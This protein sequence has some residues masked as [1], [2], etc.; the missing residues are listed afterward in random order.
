MQLQRVRLVR[1]GAGDATVNLQSSGGTHVRPTA[2]IG[3]IR[4]GKVEK[5][6]KENR[7]MNLFLDV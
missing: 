5:K 1:I 6:G 2:E 7:R 3:R 4:L